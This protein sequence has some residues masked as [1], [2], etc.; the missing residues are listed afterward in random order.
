MELPKPN[1]DDNRGT[2]Q[3]HTNLNPLSEKTHFHQSGNATHQPLAISRRSRG[4][5][6]NSWPVDL[7]FSD[8]VRA[9]QFIGGG[10][11]D[12]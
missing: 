11:T 1:K 7:H 4:P 9:V 10:L 3:V 5:S 12:C 6:A 2:R 8:Q